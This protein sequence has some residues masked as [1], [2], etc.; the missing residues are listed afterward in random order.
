MPTQPVDDTVL[1]EI[2][3]QFDSGG[4][5]ES[6]AGSALQAIDAA[7]YAIVPKE[8]GSPVQSMQS[9]VMVTSNIQGR[10][11]WYLH[12]ITSGSVVVRVVQI[13]GPK[14]TQPIYVAG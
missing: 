1:S 5:P 13:P 4:L 10:P 14:G 2:K 9:L 11:G 3:T 8:G 7:G 6:I 12:E